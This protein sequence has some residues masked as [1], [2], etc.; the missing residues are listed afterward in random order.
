MPYYHLEDE[1]T[2]QPCYDAAVY[3]IV[4]KKNGNVYVGASCFVED[5]MTTHLSGILS[6]RHPLKSIRRAFRGHKE[7]DLEF[8]ILERVDVA[9]DPNVGVFHRDMA[10]RVGTEKLNERERHWIRKLGA[11]NTKKQLPLIGVD[12]PLI[13][14]TAPAMHLASA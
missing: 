5:R 14:M 6:G 4:S 11:V 1:V 3:A 9:K 13:D 7:R 10:A 8:R 12:I 2:G